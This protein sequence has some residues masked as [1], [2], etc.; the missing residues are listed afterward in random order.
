MPAAER[1]L[2]RMSGLRHRPLAALSDRPSGN[3]PAGLAL[4][5]VHQQRAAAQI[6]RL[7]IG[8][9]RPGLPARDPRACRAAVVLGVI[10]ALTIAGAEAPERLRRA[11][12]PAFAGPAARRRR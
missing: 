9:P 6:R 12:T 3:D 10:A 1:R 7:R 2:E 5:Q 4:W 11:V 8:T